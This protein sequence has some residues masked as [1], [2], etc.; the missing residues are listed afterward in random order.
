MTPVEFHW[1]SAGTVERFFSGCFLIPSSLARQI[2]GSSIFQFFIS[3]ND[4][5]E[6]CPY[7]FLIPPLSA[8]PSTP[9]TPL[10]SFTLANGSPSTT[11]LVMLFIRFPTMVYQFFLMIHYW[12][13]Q[14]ICPQQFEQIRYHSIWISKYIWFKRKSH[15]KD[16]SSRTGFPKKS[17]NSNS[18]FIAKIIFSYSI[19][20]Y[21]HCYNT[22][23]QSIPL[24]QLSRTSLYNLSTCL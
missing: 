7:I 20:S 8:P 2:D 16:K 19:C 1:N 5:I 12:I 23:K 22:H 10:F 21:D 24:L 3:S 17:H 11:I 6:L 4:T 13:H 9:Y 18:I 14:S 15:Q